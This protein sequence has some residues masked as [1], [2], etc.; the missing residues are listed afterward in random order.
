MTL[1]SVYRIKICHMIF[2]FFFAGNVVTIHTESHS[3][4]FH[5]SEDSISIDVW[6]Q[7]FINEAMVGTGS[8]DNVREEV[9]TNPDVLELKDINIAYLESGPE[10]DA[11]VQQETEDPEI[12]SFNISFASSGGATDAQSTAER[13]I[14][15]IKLVYLDTD[16]DWTIGE[17]EIVPE[18]VPEANSS[19]GEFITNYRMDLHECNASR[20]DPQPQSSP[21]LMKANFTFKHSE[22]NHE[23]RDAECEQNINDNH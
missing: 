13:D 2:F 16:L 17:A 5:A 19:T 14:E 9:T 12:Q 21:G 1:L 18:C 11:I 20:H 8:Y 6:G 4:S 23:P 7:P 15:S 22:V 10:S 3:N